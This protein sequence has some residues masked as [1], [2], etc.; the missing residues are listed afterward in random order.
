MKQRP[1]PDW[2]EINETTIRTETDVSV[3][4]SIKYRNRIRLDET[5]NTPNKDS[6][7][8]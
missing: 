6:F 8:R 4:E 7:K 1:G 3:F 2:T 5:R